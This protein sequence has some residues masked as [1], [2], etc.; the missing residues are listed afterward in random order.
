[1]SKINKKY[2]IIGI[3][4]LS[5]L[6]IGSSYAWWR[7]QSSN[8]AVV[9]GNV[10]APTINFIGGS[11]INGT[12]IVPVTSKNNGIKKEIRVDLNDLCSSG[13]TATFN[14]KMLLNV[15]P[16]SLSHI[17]FVWEFYKLNSSNTEV[18][19]SS[20]NFAG[21][22]VGDTI[23]LVTNDTITSDESVYYLYVYINGN[24]DNPSTMGGQ[25]F[26]LDLY[27]TGTGAVSPNNSNIT[28][29]YY[30][31]FDLAANDLV[32]NTNVNADTNLASA[33]VGVD[34]TNRRVT[35]Y[36]DAAA[37]DSYNIN[38]N[39]TIDLNGKTLSVN[40]A[41]AN[42]GNGVFSLDN[43]SLLTIDGTDTGSTV[44][45]NFTDSSSNADYNLFYVKDGNINLNGGL[46]TYVYSGAG[47]SSFAKNIFSGNSLTISGTIISYEGGSI[48]F[49]NYPYAS[50]SVTISNSNITYNQTS[51]N[52]SAQSR[53]I[54]CGNDISISNSE[55]NSIHQ[56]NSTSYSGIY[57]KNVTISYLT[58]NETINRDS[59][60]IISVTNTGVIDS[61][62]L[63][64]V[65]G[66]Q[67]TR[68]YNGIYFHGTDFSVSDS[69]IDVDAPYNNHGDSSSPTVSSFGIR[70]SS[71]NVTLTNNNVKATNIGCVCGGTTNLTVEG[72][73]YGSFGHGGFYFSNGNNIGSD[74]LHNVTIKRY[75]YPRDYTGVFA[76]NTSGPSAVMYIGGGTNANNSNIKVYLDSC[77]LVGEGYN[78]FIL[79]GTEGE[80]DNSLYISNSTFTSS[81][82]SF[83]IDRT[84]NKVYFGSGNNIN[85]AW[86]SSL[87]SGVIFQYGATKENNVVFGSDSY[88]R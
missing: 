61:L 19:V 53:L 39:M 46:Y 64:G 82:S 6:G 54:Y 59:E 17:S 9:N 28:T 1:M 81:T 3:V 63:N 5:I 22:V 2:L 70:V 7:Y 69:S 79:R 33:A 48:D 78:Y 57:G 42:L 18:L 37:T 8:N 88:A 38:Q 23:N 43:N 29:D 80:H 65:S 52:S 68:S 62:T 10:C 27:G 74:Y 36:K 73:T 72:G 50:D 21:K 11:T 30:S 14:L 60:S 41:S 67:I 87:P 16:S 76:M 15:F 26:E 56:A 20:G 31:S 25:S 32:N 85:S 35:L 44:N 66:S 75:I 58:Y 34:F 83:R 86:Q 55:I 24:V 47:N 49:I 51:T 13:D 45:I 12:D 77:T 4:L 84:T 40:T 71:G